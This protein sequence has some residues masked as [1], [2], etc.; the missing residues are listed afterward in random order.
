MIFIAST[1]MNNVTNNSN[2]LLAYLQSLKIEKFLTLG[3]LAWLP[4]YQQMLTL[5]WTTYIYHIATQDIVRKRFFAVIHEIVVL[6]LRLLKTIF[7]YTFS[8]LN[9]SDVG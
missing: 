3:T 2:N 5:R 8:D 6:H 4:A 9:V 1:N 7:G